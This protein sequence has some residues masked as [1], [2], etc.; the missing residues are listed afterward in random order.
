MVGVLLAEALKALV[1]TFLDYEGKKKLQEQKFDLDRSLEEFKSSLQEGLDKQERVFQSM[2]EVTKFDLNRRE[3][4]FSLYS[5]KRH[6]TYLLLHQA[7][8]DAESRVMSLYGYTNFTDFSKFSLSEIE[9]WLNKNS[10]VD[11]QKH[12]VLDFWKDNKTK[13]VNNAVYL[14]NL[15]RQNKA[16]VA[17]GKAKNTMLDYQL[18]LS[19]EVFSLSSKLILDIGKLNTNNKLLG[20]R[21]VIEAV[22]LNEES[23]ILRDRINEE[24]REI[25][26][27]M[28]TELQ[29]GYYEEIK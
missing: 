13:A 16:D 2:L 10:F 18:Y 15:L 26:K 6:E 28:K 1:K 27:K 29:K 11:A 4:D 20:S 19:E 17:V 14:E 23:V 21:V 24:F 5:S 25:T 8:L 9:D 22:K 12:S 7:I 3:K